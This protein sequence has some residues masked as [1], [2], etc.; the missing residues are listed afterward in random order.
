MH[1]EPRH[2]EVTQ[3]RLTLTYTP[4]CTLDFELL[5]DY[6]CAFRNL[7]LLKKKTF[8]SSGSTIQPAGGKSTPW[9]GGRR[10]AAFVERY[11]HILLET[12]FAFMIMEKLLPLSKPKGMAIFQ[13]ITVSWCPPWDP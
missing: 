10:K 12:Q 9:E 11:R 8:G 3:H 4:L 7:S 2:D 1:L 13:K 6:H 5:F